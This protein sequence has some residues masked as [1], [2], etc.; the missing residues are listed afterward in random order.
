MR[1][2]VKNLSETIEVWEQRAQMK[3]EQA[4]R[5]GP[6]SFR[7]HELNGEALAIESCVWELRKTYINGNPLIPAIE[8]KE[9]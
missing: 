8:K 2:D 5:L 3:R 7:H 4:K 9:E 6:R 1:I